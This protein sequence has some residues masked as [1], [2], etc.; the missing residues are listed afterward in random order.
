MNDTQASLIVFSGT[1]PT[2]GRASGNSYNGK[3]TFTYLLEH[4][5]I[6]QLI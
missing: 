4:L 1:C 3:I 5:G 2:I 6:S